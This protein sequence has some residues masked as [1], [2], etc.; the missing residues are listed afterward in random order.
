MKTVKTG[1]IRITQEKNIEE[2]RYIFSF[3][4]KKPYEQNNKTVVI[5]TKEQEEIELNYYP[6]QQDYKHV[7]KDHIVYSLL[8]Q[9][10][11]LDFSV[12]Y[13]QDEK[14]DGYLLDTIKAKFT[15]TEVLTP[16]YC[17]FFF[18]MSFPRQILAM[19]GRDYLL[20]ICPTP[21]T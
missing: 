7:A 2:E 19:Y 9:Q 8:L 14:K 17:D 20:Y 12:L 10:M 1:L 18:Y 6:Y 3:I 4:K 21:T 13:F 15:S 11:M 16:L 5:I